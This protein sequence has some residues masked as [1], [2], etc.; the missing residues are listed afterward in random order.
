VRFYTNGKLK[1]VITKHHNASERRLA[2][3][4]LTDATVYVQSNPEW[5]AS[6]I[7]GWRELGW[8][9]AGQHSRALKVLGNA[10]VNEGGGKGG[11]VYVS[12]RFENV[13]DLL[14]AVCR[15]RITLG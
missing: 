5:D 14:D 2:L 4:L 6:R 8:T 11:G 3:K 15:R 1:A 7:P 13:P 9:S 12:E 10:I